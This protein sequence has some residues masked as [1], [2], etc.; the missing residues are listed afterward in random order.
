MDGFSLNPL[1]FSE[2]PATSPVDEKVRRRKKNS[3]KYC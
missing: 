1:F 2:N 3:M